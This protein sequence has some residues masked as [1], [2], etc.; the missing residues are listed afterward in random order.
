[1]SETPSKLR[2]PRK[3]SAKI[4][5]DALNDGRFDP[6]LIENLRI[7]Q[8]D[9]LGLKKRKPQSP[10]RIGGNS[11]KN[12]GPVPPT[13]TT[14]VPRRNPHNSLNSNRSSLFKP[15]HKTSLLISN[16]L[17]RKPIVSSINFGGPIKTN[18]E[19][20]ENKVKL[21]NCKLIFL[22]N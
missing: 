20:Q 8:E 5:L 4:D 6:N 10:A 21:V 22:F 16:S 15:K 9:N 14:T 3:L 19:E 17:I 13:T 12:G 18:F 1:M 7:D 11:L 2:Q